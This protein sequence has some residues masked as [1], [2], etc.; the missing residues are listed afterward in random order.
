M[1]LLHLHLHLFVQEKQDYVE[2]FVARATLIV[3]FNVFVDSAF[4]L[5]GIIDCLERLDYVERCVKVMECKRVC[6]NL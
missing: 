4:W 2:R 5:L 6:N 3:F 1:F